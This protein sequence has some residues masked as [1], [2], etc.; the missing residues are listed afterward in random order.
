MARREGQRG[1][2][3]S[4]REN[5]KVSECRVQGAG[6]YQRIE[7]FREKQRVESRES[8]LLRS[9]RKRGKSYKEPSDT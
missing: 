1:G 5:Q 6:K 7:S 3:Q 2:V 9:V 8:V 4:V